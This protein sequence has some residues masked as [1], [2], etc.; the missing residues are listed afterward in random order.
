MNKYK[1]ALVTK[2]K[3]ESRCHQEVQKLCMWQIA[4]ML[5]VSCQH[6]NRIYFLDAKNRTKETVLK[7]HHE[8]MA[9]LS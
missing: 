7:Q 2:M 3:E 5:K 9:T 4:Q 6:G 8:R 1:V